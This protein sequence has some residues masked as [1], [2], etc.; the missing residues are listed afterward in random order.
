MD[1]ETARAIAHLID[2][3]PSCGAMVESGVLVTAGAPDEDVWWVDAGSDAHECG[4]RIESVK[5]GL[6]FIH[7]HYT[8]LAEE[9]DN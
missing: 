1:E 4:W 9:G 3:I 7:D 5:E 6:R 2:S 8:L